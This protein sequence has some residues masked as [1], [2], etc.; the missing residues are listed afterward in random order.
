MTLPDP[1]DSRSEYVA[2]EHT[3]RIDLELYPDASYSCPIAEID[4]D[5]EEIEYNAM[6]DECRVDLL[7][8]DGRVVRGT[9][10]LEEKEC[11]CSLF[12]DLNCVPHYEG[13][14]EGVILVST[15]LDNQ[16]DVRE[17][18]DRLR[19]V[20]STVRLAR[21][22]AIGDETGQRTVL[23]DLSVLTAKQREALELA[24]GQGYYDDDDVDLESLASELEISTAA[25]SKRLR[26]A[27][28][29]LASELVE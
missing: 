13:I 14:D 18:I 22:T 9:D 25:L 2:G 1:V 6:D 17:L 3:L 29:N 27:Q 7:L 19:N 24:V 12:R 11:F 26:R 16:A 21:L 8:I 15:Y 4:S 20:S 23:L 10:E 28:A 5:V